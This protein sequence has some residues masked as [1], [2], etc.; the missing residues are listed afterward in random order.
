MKFLTKG[1]FHEPQN[2]WLNEPGYSDG[3][4]ALAVGLVAM[5][6]PCDLPVWLGKPPF[7][8]P[9]SPFNRLKRRFAD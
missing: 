4:I 5:S 1:A 8:W 9:R 3:S 6:W 7:A 2:I